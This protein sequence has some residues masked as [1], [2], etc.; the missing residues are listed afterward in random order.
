[1]EK[2]TI[3]KIK[4]SMK[5]ASSQNT[6]EKAVATITIGPFKIKGLRILESKWENRHGDYLWVVPPSYQSKIGKFHKAFYCENKEIWREIEDKILEE[7]KCQK[8]KQLKDEI[9]IVEDQSS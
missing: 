8:A 3:E 2:I 9:P 6:S 4:V 1:M 5:L 7:Y